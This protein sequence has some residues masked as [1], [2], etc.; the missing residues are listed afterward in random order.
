[1]GGTKSRLAKKQKRI[2]LFQCQNLQVLKLSSLTKRPLC[3]IDWLTKRNRQKNSNIRTLIDQ[4]KDSNHSSS[5]TFLLDSNVVNISALMDREKDGSDAVRSS[6]YCLPPRG[7]PALPPGHHH[8]HHLTRLCHFLHH[9]HHKVSTITAN[10]FNWKQP[11]Q[12]SIHH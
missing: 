4:E 2:K 1:M 10:K 5:C 8:H 3:L 12:Q 11:M 7:C 6:S 9:H